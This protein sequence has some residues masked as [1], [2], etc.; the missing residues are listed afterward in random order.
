[1]AAPYHLLDFY[2]RGA[3]AEFLAIGFLPLVMLG[4]RRASERSPTLLTF[5]YAGLILAHLPLAL[6]ASLFLIAPYCL[7]KGN[8]RVFALPLVLGVA[9]GAVYLVPALALNQLRHS[10]LLWADPQFQP[11]SWS[12]LFPRPG[13]VEGMRTVFATLLL[14]SLVPAAVMWRAGQRRIPFYVLVLAVV[15]AGVVPG[16]WA[17]PLV[18][19]V[20]FP[21]RMLPLI[22]LAIAT[23]IASAAFSE[24][25]TLLAVFPTLILTP[26][27]VLVH[28]QEHVPSMAHL[29]AFHPDVPEN[30]LV[31]AGP[32]P[33][34]PEQVGLLL[35]LAALAFVL[36]LT[37]R[38]ARGPHR[39]AAASSR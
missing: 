11:T 24:R 17:L 4:L 18:K 39:A 25:M 9:L 5:S 13:P 31:G 3:Q 22:D 19:D 37:L 33:L 30:Q 10:E 28:Q 35:S 16:I 29:A 26:V 12:L 2:G 32:L 15:A 21:F 6:L 38:S 23:G 8:I 34:W 14:A 7:C 20:Q 27:F 36:G 1:M